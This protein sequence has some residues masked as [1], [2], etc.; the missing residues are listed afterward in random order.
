MTTMTT[1]G[2]GDIV[3]ISMY[4]RVFHIIL[5]GIGTILYSFIVSKIGNALR[6]QSYEHMKLSKDLAILENIRLT[7]PAMPFKLY[8]KIQKHLLKISQK[9]KKTGLSL[10]INGIPDTI[11]NELLL[12]IYS[13]TINSFSIFKEVHN[14]NF[15]LQVLTSFI[16]IIAKKEE[17]IILEGELID[18]II[19]VKD[20]RLSIEAS[21]DLN[22][23]YNSIRHFLLHNFA[24]ISKKEEKKI[25]NNTN[26]LRR[27][28]SILTIKSKNFKDL[29]NE[30]DN[31]L[32][33]NQKTVINKN[34][35]ID[36]NGIS[37]D[38]GRMN[39]TENDIEETKI[40]GDNHLIKIIDIRKNE[41]FGDVQMLLQKPCPFTIIAKSRIAEILLLRKNDVIILSKAFPNIWRRIYNKSYHNL[42]SIKELTF[43]KLKR[44]YNTYFY[45]K[46]NKTFFTSN[47]DITANSKISRKSS[48]SEISKIIRKTKTN[49]INNCIN[50]K[51]NSSG[52]K[53]SLKSKKLFI[54]H[55]HS[56]KSDDNI[57]CNEISFSESFKSLKENNSLKNK[58][59]KEESDFY[60]NN[61][62]EIKNNLSSKFIPKNLGL[63][64]ITF[65]KESTIKNSNQTTKEL[66]DNK[67][68]YMLDIYKKESENSSKR[69]I[70]DNCTEKISNAS[71]SKNN[72]LILEDI[73][74]D[75]A[76]K[77]KKKINERNKIQKIKYL[78]EYQN[79]KYK[80]NLIDIF[81]QFNQPQN[82]NTKMVNNLTNL[83]NTIYEK[84]LDISFS[85]SNNKI[86]SQ[87]IESED[88]SN[89]ST[90]KNSHFNMELLKK[91]SNESFEIKS[92]YENLN[93]LSK[94]EIINNLKYKSFIESLF[95]G[96]L[97]N[98][99]NYDLE[100]V[101]NI[102]S[103]LNMSVKM[104]K[105]KE[106]YNYHKKETEK[107]DAFLNLHAMQLNMKTA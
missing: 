83:Y 94:G 61:S 79:Q 16:P 105:Y 23:P 21:I 86:F 54:G 11:K 84:I 66:I 34:S 97:K 7:Y 20:G 71:S 76:K 95:N 62:S 91:V 60:S 56:K 103:G 53:N 2:Y 89:L 33:D 44:Y 67:N 8:S 69:S 31:F 12:K 13:K 14:S 9:R 96:Y 72:F 98:I 18:N 15:I 99:N 3:C 75:F 65:K 92:S 30:I 5:L 40:H 82:L 28:N 58:N 32:L 26:N 10:L 45:N 77:I 35:L 85:I 50:K 80:N 63:T 68:K 36:N 39:F 47:L 102:I 74:A 1:V 59:N 4:E 42:V 93:S 106:E 17:I 48:K 101:N 81:S 70:K 87:F 43:K 19:F 27:V 46:D 64:K 6:D 37:M 78:F 52:N 22:D 55:T 90:Q 104:E 38:L 49:F 25:N 29:K 73:N 88:D 51:K 57:T 107:S 41:H 100:N 24:G